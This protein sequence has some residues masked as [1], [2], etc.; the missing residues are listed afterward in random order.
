MKR[1]TIYAG[2]SFDK[3]GARIP[4]QEA[5][6]MERAVRIFASEQFGGATNYQHVGSWLSN[7]ELVSESG[8]TFVVF[9]PDTAS[10]SQIQ[11]L[12]WYIRDMF[13]QQSVVVTVEN[14][15]AVFV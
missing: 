13:R 12:G 5:E 11:D 2:S 8:R 6:R 10:D 14:V 1:V 4:W 9:A 15:N 7:G 3:S